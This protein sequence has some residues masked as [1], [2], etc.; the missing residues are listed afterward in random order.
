M[1]DNEFFA[2]LDRLGVRMHVSLMGGSPPEKFCMEERERDWCVYYSER[3]DRIDE[4][5]HTS[6][7]AA[8]NDLLDRVRAAAR[9]L[10]QPPSG[11]APSIHELPGGPRP[12]IEP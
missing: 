6:R 7:D 5:C 1:T 11:R 12:A 9:Y 8:L 2:E 3:G 4:A 10:T